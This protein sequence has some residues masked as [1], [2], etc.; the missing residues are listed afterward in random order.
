MAIEAKASINF[1][2]A[3]ITSSNRIQIAENLIL[4]QNR[5]G[6]SDRQLEQSN[7]EN[8]IAKK[9]SVIS[10]RRGLVGMAV[11]SLVS[12][13]LL[14]L[15]FTPPASK[16]S[17]T[18][19]TA[20][21]TKGSKAIE[22]DRDSSSELKDLPPVKIQPSPVMSSDSPGYV[23]EKKLVE[24]FEI[25]QLTVLNSNTEINVVAESIE[26]LER[27]DEDL[28]RK[29][30]LKLTQIADSRGIE[31]LIKILSQVSPTEQSL[32]LKAIIQ[33]TER[34]LQ[35]I[36]DVLF[37]NSNNVNSEIKQNAI[38]DLS[39]LYAFV[40]PITKQ[41]AQMQVDGDIQVQRTATIAIDRL[42]FYLPC[43]FNNYP[44]R[45]EF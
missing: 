27:S 17:S 14:K 40:A 42:N 37:S 5:I 2:E 36:E 34:S 35:P 26:Y 13:I 1:S 24:N 45:A 18:P 28:R 41:L 38:H 4:T 22:N 23:L 16:I 15:M 8:P 20:T 19:K 10:K 7:F 39:A 31:P 33:I 30:I 32:I 11:V 9:S 25:S 12:L 3:I 43:L 6:N 44:D 21:K 29:A